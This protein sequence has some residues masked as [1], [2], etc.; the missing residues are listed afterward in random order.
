MILLAIKKANYEI[1]FIII[2]LSIL[3]LV[4]WADDRLSQNQ[5][6]HTIIYHKIQI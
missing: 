2:F 3:Y 5:F 4:I 1:I 6:S